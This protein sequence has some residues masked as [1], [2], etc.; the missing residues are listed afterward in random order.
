MIRN[1]LALLLVLGLAACGRPPEVQSLASASAPVAI[2]LQTSGDALQARFADQRFTLDAYA[3]E[4][5]AQASRARSYSA[6]VE[7]DW[8]FVDDK[9]ALRQWLMLHEDDAA[10]RADPLAP[11]LTTITAISVPPALDAGPIN[12]VVGNLAALGQPRGPQI[13]ELFG[14]AQS[15]NA[16]L[17][18][19]DAAKPK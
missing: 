16:E 6:G 17:A 5:G 19:L 10:V 14:F 3:G 9:K 15:V 12:V 4:L 13:D 2:G 7:R 11:V 8:R 1:T 18:K